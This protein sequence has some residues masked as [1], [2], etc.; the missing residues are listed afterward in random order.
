[1]RRA[2]SVNTVLIDGQVA[3]SWTI[4]DDRVV[5][6]AFDGIPSRFRDELEVERRALESFVT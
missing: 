6:E 2:H 1:M 4:D 5:V 3:G